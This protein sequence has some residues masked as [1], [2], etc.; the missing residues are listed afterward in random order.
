MKQGVR[1]LDIVTNVRKVQINRNVC[2]LLNGMFHRLTY[3]L[4]TCYIYVEYREVIL[5]NKI[6][7]FFKSY[8]NLITSVL[9]FMA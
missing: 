6:F 8:K 5:G 9:I 7:T 1:S 4:F 3:A 2:H